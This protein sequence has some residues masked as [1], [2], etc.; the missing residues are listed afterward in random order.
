MKA[1]PVRSRLVIAARVKPGAS[2]T[3]VGG[4]HHRP[5]GPALVV[6]VTARAVDGAATEA[7]LR[8]MAEELG[9]G[10]GQVSLVRGRT[11][12]D[13]VLAVDEPPRRCGATRGGVAAGRAPATGP[14]AAQV[15]VE[16]AE[17]VR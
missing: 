12:R 8:A 11:G 13:K 10:R 15:S 5:G 17:A 7:V 1:D 6:A 3:V 9:V 14:R 4:R 2:G 16:P